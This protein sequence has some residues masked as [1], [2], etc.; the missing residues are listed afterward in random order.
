AHLVEREGVGSGHDRRG[1][2]H[3][4]HHVRF[5]AY[6]AEQPSVRARRLVG[7]ILL[8]GRVP[9]RALR[10]RVSNLRRFGLG[11]E[12]DV[13]D[14]RAGRDP[15]L[16]RMRVVVRAD[17]VVA[18]VRK[19]PEHAIEV[20]ANH[21]IAYLKIEIPL[22]GRVPLDAITLR[23]LVEDFLGHELCDELFVVLGLAELVLHGRRQ[24]GE[25]GIDLV[26]RELPSADDADHRTERVGLRRVPDL[27]LLGLGAGPGLGL[28]TVGAAAQNEDG[29]EHRRGAHHRTAAEDEG[30]SARGEWR[31]H[32]RTT[33]TFTGAS[34]SWKRWTGTSTKTSALS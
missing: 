2:A 24:R 13:P 28:G 25:N 30:P 17:L 27:R 11:R 34:T 4:G 3:A 33:H 23:G 16:V 31:R 22:V 6:P 9:E 29:D 32:L 12:R 20:V 8:A 18:D 14:L 15:E 21:E 26:A 1:I 10:E 7:R 19:R 5:L